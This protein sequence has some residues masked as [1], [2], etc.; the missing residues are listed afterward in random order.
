MRRKRV[1]PASTDLHSDD[2]LKVRELQEGLHAQ[3]TASA[4][5][6]VQRASGRRG[7]VQMSRIEDATH[8]GEED[9]TCAMRAN[10][11]HAPSAALHSEEHA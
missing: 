5:Q 3:A 10:T 7:G 2:A 4:A 8:A 1:A 9:L 11:K 6:I